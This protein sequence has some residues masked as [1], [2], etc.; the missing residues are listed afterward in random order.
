MKV[1]IDTHVLLWFQASDKALTQAHRQI[2]NAPENECSVSI[3]S[4]WEIAIKHS[5][6]KLPLQK[7]LSAFFDTVHQAEF[8]L[9]PV[10]EQHIHML[11]TLPLHRRDPFDR[12]LIAQARSEGMHILTADPHFAAYEVPLA[13]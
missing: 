5:M 3:V 13:G 7:G 9:M 4:F 10:L 1:L 6:G 8:P 11:S 2:I 12:M